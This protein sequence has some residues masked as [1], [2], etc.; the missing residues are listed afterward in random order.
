MEIRLLDLMPAE[1]PMDEIVCN[2]RI[3]QMTEKSPYEALSYTWGD[4]PDQRTILL[5]G[6]L[7]AITTNLWTAIRYLRSD[8][9]VRTL[10]VDALFINQNNIIEK[11]YMVSQMHVIYH[12]ANNVIV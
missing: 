7:F 5:N 6:Q 3:M 10:W 2:H 8:S 4:S 9:H 11:S 12:H 1:S